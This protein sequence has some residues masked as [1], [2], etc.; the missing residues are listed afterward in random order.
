MISRVVVNYPRK[1][2]FSVHPEKVGPSPDR[3]SPLGE[4]TG[5]RRIYCVHVSRGSFRENCVRRDVGSVQ[6][7]ERRGIPPSVGGNSSLVRTPAGPLFVRNR[8]EPIANRALGWTPET[9]PTPPHG[10]DLAPHL[11]ST[12]PYRTQDSCPK[13]HLN[14]TRTQPSPKPYHTVS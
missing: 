14:P 8:G 12:S 10:P 13:P 3:A 5:W 4:G 9:L 7:V 6:L 11:R 2:F 1:M